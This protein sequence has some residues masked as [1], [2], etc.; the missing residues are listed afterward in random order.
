MNDQ[1][2]IIGTW[3]V[4]ISQEEPI[5]GNYYDVIKIKVDGTFE[6]LTTTQ[7]RHGIYEKKDDQLILYYGDH[8]FHIYHIF[9]QS[10]TIEN[11]SLDCR[12]KK[13]TFIK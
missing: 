9:K 12:Y 1:F 8:E 7:D 10:K 13:I 3:E 5:S 6:H 11:L 2:S 4:E